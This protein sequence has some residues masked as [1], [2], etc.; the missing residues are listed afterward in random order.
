MRM[1]PCREPTCVISCRLLRLQEDWTSTGT[2]RAAPHADARVICL[3]IAYGA[4]QGSSAD[5][6]EQLHRRAA[7]TR[8]HMPGVSHRVLWPSYIV[9]QL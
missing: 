2:A 4:L 9:G 6:K 5:G 7:V 8:A 3:C 1:Q